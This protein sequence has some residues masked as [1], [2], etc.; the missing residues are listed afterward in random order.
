ML[1]IKR[2][3]TVIVMCTIL[4]IADIMDLRFITNAAC[5]AACRSEIDS[6]D[7]VLPYLATIDEILLSSNRGVIG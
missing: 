1:D 3:P 6:F 7:C 2:V 4:L 5:D